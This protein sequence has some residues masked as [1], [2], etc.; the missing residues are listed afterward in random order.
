MNAT[1]RCQYLSF[2]HFAL[3]FRTKPRSIL[4]TMTKMIADEEDRTVEGDFIGSNRATEIAA[5]S[6][7][8]TRT[9]VSSRYIDEKLATAAVK[10]LEVGNLTPIIKEELRLTIQTRRLKKGLDELEVA[11]REPTEEQVGAKCS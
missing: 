3:H 8:T 5:K 10:S 1:P 2:T 11:F 7:N 4:S 9:S 6:L